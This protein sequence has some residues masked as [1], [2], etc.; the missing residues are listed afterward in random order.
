MAFRE[1]ACRIRSGHAAQNLA[2]LRHL[3]LNLLRHET[4]CRRGIEG[5]RK[6]AAW[7]DDYMLEVLTSLTSP[8]NKLS[9]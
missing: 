3:A 7:N 2:T 6:K 9:P 4:S 1:D 5:K 8:D